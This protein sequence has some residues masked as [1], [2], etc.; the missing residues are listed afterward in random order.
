MTLDKELRDAIE[1]A[2]R[3][4]SSSCLDN[5]EELQAVLGDVHFSVSLV[6]GAHILDNIYLFGAQ[7]SAAPKV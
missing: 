3:R 1:K 5:E 7:K 6:W 2:L 4:H